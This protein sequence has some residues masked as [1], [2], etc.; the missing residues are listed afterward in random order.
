MMYL[1]RFIAGLIPARGGDKIFVYDHLSNFAI[2]KHF[3]SRRMCHCVGCLHEILT[4]K[5][6]TKPGL[7]DRNLGLLGWNLG[8]LGSKLGVLSSSMTCIGIGKFEAVDG[9]LLLPHSRLLMPLSSSAVMWQQFLIDNI[10]WCPVPYVLWT[11]P[12]WTGSLCPSQFCFLFND[13]HALLNLTSSSRGT[14]YDFLLRWRM[15]DTS[16][17]RSI[18]CSYSRPFFFKVY[19]TFGFRFFGITI[20]MVQY[21]ICHISTYT[22]Q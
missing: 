10:F 17:P 5:L 20:F 13:S 22:Y 11:Q 21:E 16:I 2:S 15:K 18:F 8:L 14:L 6:I 19:M 1:A 3:S 7:L 12:S 9:L 4:S